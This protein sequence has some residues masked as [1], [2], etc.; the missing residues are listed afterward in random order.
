MQCCSSAR[1]A[2]AHFVCC[3]HLP[4]T[5]AARLWHAGI[6]GLR[7]D[8]LDLA[9]AHGEAPEEDGA[10][11]AELS[12]SYYMWCAQLAVGAQCTARNVPWSAQQC[13]LRPRLVLCLCAWQPRDVHPTC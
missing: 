7:D 6:I 8:M 11:H 13:S 9:R 12:H 10:E 2:D 1:R 4:Q 3:A 5:Y